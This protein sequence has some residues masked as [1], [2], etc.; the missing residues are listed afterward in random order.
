[1]SE[2]SETGDKAGKAYW[3]SVWNDSELPSLVDPFSNNRNNYTAR[4][5]HALFSSLFA[6]RDCHGA[7]LLEIGCARSVWLPYFASQYGF[8][9]SG[10]DYSELGCE[11][12]RALLRKAQINGEIVHTDFFHPPRRLNGYFDV[13][14]SFGV[15]EHFSDT[16]HCLAAFS[17]YLRPGGM[18]ITVVP[19]MT[20]LMGL[21]Q[22]ILDRTVY[23]IH[24]PLGVSTLRVAHEACGLNVEFCRYFMSTGFGVLNTDKL[25]GNRF[26]SWLK[27]GLA[28]NLSRFS[29]G[30]ALLEERGIKFPATHCLSPYVLCVSRK[31]LPS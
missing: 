14:T 28:S 24:V 29:K 11:Q 8:S 10:V 12:A 13:V 18:M 27:R 25:P 20:W 19:N 6:G 1:M 22:K 5:F 4:R 26:S 16:S 3:S 23:D 17:S 15:V 2:D 30:A 9:V 7:R 21:L 31:D